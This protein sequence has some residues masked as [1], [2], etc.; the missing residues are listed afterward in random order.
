M[1]RNR[2]RMAIGVFA[3]AGD[4]EVIVARLRALG[5]AHHD[6]FPLPPDQA[7]SDLGL[8][9]VDRQSGKSPLVAGPVV[10]RIHLKTAAD[11]QAV[12]RTLLDST[13][14]SVQLHDVDPPPAPPR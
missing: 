11:E 12:V 7:L 3:T 2:R 14:Q 1:N 9:E 5:I 6:C 8:E 10:L 4:A 13:A